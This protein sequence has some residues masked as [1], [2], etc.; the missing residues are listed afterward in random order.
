M[1]RYRNVGIVI[2]WSLCA[3]QNGR[4]GVVGV[5]DG[6]ECGC[7]EMLVYEGGIVKF[8]DVCFVQ[9]LGY[10]TLVSMQVCELI[11][12]NRDNGRYTTNH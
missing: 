1:R 12:I 9:M 10:L 7:W 11:Q 5:W 8:G 3:W 4:G 6:V 2:V